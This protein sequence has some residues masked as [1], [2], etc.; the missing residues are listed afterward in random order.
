M[1][2]GSP[3]QQ[4]ADKLI[5]D[6]KLLVGVDDPEW[7]PGRDPGSQR[8][9]LPLQVNGE[10]IG[11]Q[12]E[13]K[14]FPAR[15]Q[16]WFCV[17]VLFGEMCIDRLD[18]Q[19]TDHANPAGFGLRRLVNGPHWHSWELNRHQFSNAKNFK[20]LHLASEFTETR[21][22]DAALRWY[23]KQR[24][25]VLGLHGIAMPHPVDLL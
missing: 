2:K 15:N 14:A 9:K 25:I 24:N 12:L 4:A 16:P 8:L 1:A 5:A 13:I 20:T 22:F 10:Q 19:Q 18:V 11:A 3:F 21:Q 7:Q 23:C 6:Q 17:G